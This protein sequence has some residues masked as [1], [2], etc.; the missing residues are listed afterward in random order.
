MFRQTIRKQVS[1]SKCGNKVKTRSVNESGDVVNG[2]KLCVVL[3][4]LVGECVV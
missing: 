2:A 3:F 4:N 1:T